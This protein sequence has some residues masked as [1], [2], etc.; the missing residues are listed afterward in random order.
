MSTDAEQSAAT[1]APAAPPVNKNKRYRKDKPWDNDEIDHWAIEPVTAAAPLDAPL[2]E[3]SF[4][5]LFPKYREKY[6]REVWPLVTRTLKT[7]GVGCELNL[8]EGSMTVKTTRKTWDPSIILKARDLIKLLA[9]SLPVLQ[10]LKILQDG[11]YTDIIKIKNM[12][13]NKERYV[14]RRQ[15]LIGPNGCT[16]KA[17]ELVTNCYVLVQGNTVS[18]MGSI[19]GLKAVRKIVTECM[20]NVHPIYNIKILMIKKELAADP[21]LKEENWDRFLPSFKKK[22]V[23]RK[24]LSKSDKDAAKEKEAVF[25][26]FPPAPTPRKVD[27]ALESGEYFLSQAEKEHRAKEEKQAKADEKAQQ[28]RQARE[29]QFTAPEEGA[30][31]AEDSSSKKE[32]KKSKKHA[33]DEEAPATDDAAAA[34][35]EEPKAKKA[36]KSKREDAEAGASAAAA[37]ASPAAPAA[38]ASEERAL[39]NAKPS[40]KK[41]RGE[42]K[43]TVPEHERRAAQEA[44]AASSSASSVDVAALKSKFKAAHSAVTKAAKGGGQDATAFVQGMAAASGGDDGKPS[45]KQKK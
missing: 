39:P 12:V 14:K 3:S 35:D 16:L 23:Q 2:E 5:T 30:A 11:V 29:E 7:Y 40:G 32:K 42:A 38:A 9:R 10:A 24:K 4:A 22:N 45:K 26:P 1:G 27:M 31:A 13:R 43:A 28:K 6:L 41:K 44:A 36:K 21:A 17:I 33:R 20:Q 8:V 18:A 25:T 15:R 37:A 34:G 19:H